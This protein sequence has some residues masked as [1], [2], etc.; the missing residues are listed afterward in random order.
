MKRFKRTLAL[1]LAMLMLLG[2]M[3]AAYAETAT[4]TTLR[5]A[6]SSGTV[7]ITNS[8]G[9][10]QTVKTDMRLYSGYSVSTEKQSSAYISLD[11]TK[12][13][14][15]DASSKSSVRKAGNKLE[16]FLNDGKLFFNVT[17]PLA[18]DES[19]NIRTS[20]MVTGIRGSFGWV[21]RNEVALLHGHVTLTCINPV[22]GAVRVTE[23]YSGERVYYDPDSTV[24]ADPEL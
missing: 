5:L 15:L 8:S 12:A 23:L 21:A 16:V 11:G 7:S 9:K 18:A 6:G 2:V 20:T 17:A 4:A 24:A 14:K 1:V 3:S 10:E 19:L 13:V 22:T